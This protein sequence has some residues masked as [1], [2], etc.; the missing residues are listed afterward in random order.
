MMETRQTRQWKYGSISSP[1]SAMLLLL[2]IISTV[3]LDT[4]SLRG[5]T[6]TAYTLSLHLDTANTISS[7]PVTFVDIS[8]VSANFCTKFHMTDKQSN[9]HFVTKFG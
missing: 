7:P 6:Y 3:V 4:R 2:V 5:S 9:I 1:F 8:A